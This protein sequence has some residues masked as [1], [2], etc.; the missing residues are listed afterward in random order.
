MVALV[1]QQ[2]ALLGVLLHLDLGLVRRSLF[3]LPELGLP[4]SKHD[5]LVGH[6]RQQPPVLLLGKVSILRCLVYDVERV[7]LV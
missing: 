3:P 4:F 1:V 2:S 6:L 5:H 7:Q